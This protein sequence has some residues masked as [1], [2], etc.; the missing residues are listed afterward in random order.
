MAGSVRGRKLPKREQW[1]T[2]CLALLAVLVVVAMQVSGVRGDD[3]T[4]KAKVTER[5]YFDIMIDGAHAGRIV[6]GLYG[7]VAPKTVEN[8]VALATNKNGY[9]YKNSIFHRIIRDFMVQ[10]GDFEKSN[11]TGGYSIYGDKFD[12]EDFSVKFTGAGDLAM[13]NSG[14]DTNGSQ[15][16]ITTAKT[17]WLDGKHVIFGLVLRGMNIVHR[18][19]DQEGTPPRRE[20]LIKDCGIFKEYNPDEAE[21]YELLEQEALRK[22][23]ADHRKA[24]DAMLAEHFE[25]VKKKQRYELEDS[26]GF[27]DKINADGGFYSPYT[28]IVFFIIIGTIVGLV[29]LQPVKGGGTKKSQ[30]FTKLATTDV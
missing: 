18:M 24:E 15:F 21:D 25:N 1:A 4:P 2:R 26:N 30:A 5:V 3:V 14:P 29:M 9:G 13:A 22:E 12:D 11:G 10:G 6:M 20:V 8:F 28:F 17:D 23:A 7:E 16:F 27:F 19:E